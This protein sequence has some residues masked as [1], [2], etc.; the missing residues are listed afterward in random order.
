MS[1]NP[2]SSTAAQERRAALLQALVPVAVKHANAQIDAFSARL[3]NALLATAHAARDPQRARTALDAG[4]LLKDNQYA[5][6]HLATVH[7]ERQL[8]AALAALLRS[9]EPAA[10]STSLADLTLVSYDEMDQKVSL[11]AASRLF[12]H[13]HESALSTLCA[14][15]AALLEQ[16][17]LPLA[18][19]PFRPEVFLEAVLSAWSEFLPETQQS[20]S[21]LPLLRPELF[22]D[23]APILKAVDQ[24][25]ALQGVEARTAAVARSKSGRA[26]GEALAPQTSQ[27]LRRL[28]GADEAA[29][30]TQSQ[31]GA[32][33]AAQPVHPQLMQALSRLQKDSG[34]PIDAPP[35]AGADADLRARLA[36]LPAI[37]QQLPQGA[38]SRMDETVLDL[39]TQVFDTVFEDPNIPDEIKELIG[40]LQVP[41]FK[42]ALLE[43]EFFFQ[44]AHPARRLI[45]VLSK[46]GLGW[47][48][49]KGRN[50]PLYQTM[51]RN[52]DRVQQD[53][54]RE[55][56]LFSD[57]VSDMEAFI[58][59]DE[60]ATE[61]ALS[62]PIAQ[63]V[64]TE[65][66]RIATRSAEEEVAVRLAT[67]EVVTFVEAFLE[68]RW[69]PILSLAYSVK[70]EKPELLRS[71]VQTM[72][73][74][75]WSVKPK[76]TAA[77]RKELISKLPGLLAAL[78]KWITL[79]KWEDAER[80]Q[81]FAELAECHASIVRAPLELSPQRQMEVAVE[82]ARLAAEKR[83]ARAASAPP[84]PAVDE[85]VQAVETLERGMWL[86]FR[87]KDGT[88]K[89][90]KLAW[91]S[92]LRSLY[93][94]SSSGKDE[95]FS[96]SADALAQA[97]REDRAHVMQVGDLVDR[98]LNKAMENVDTV[99][100][101]EVAPV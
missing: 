55:V 69:V 4:A 91:V 39:L 18:K 50:D 37:R 45:E 58:A 2:S 9:P 25:L 13:A 36:Q 97:L 43:K 56:A 32:G 59:D 15:L 28:F 62:T 27:K 5:F 63:A 61:Q 64:N 92:P 17:A 6:F 14:R 8:R 86:G 35:L 74:L 41:V 19:N 48:R 46:S 71:A 57:V 81:F 29:G 44:Q 72:D 76:Y 77:E 99:I 67:G 22:V 68:K 33:A 79:M 16:Q 95:A 89:K 93:I 31:T 82:A 10:A 83:A 75:I 84:A 24:S 80:I 52:V 38:L 1:A 40:L 70:D 101:G 65:K 23:L 11:G 90:L 30:G 78:N 94:F 3:S 42:A 26:G 87:Q 85:F 34:I 47:N 21:I 60:A 12:E 100:G 98:A 49:E 7:I 88:E 96:M 66:M 54:D 53:F 73:E 51:K 20:I